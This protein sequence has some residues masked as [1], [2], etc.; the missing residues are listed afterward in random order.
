MQTVWT[1]RAYPTSGQER[2]LILP[3]VLANIRTGNLMPGSKLPAA[4][5]HTRLCNGLR[6][7]DKL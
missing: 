7:G 5:P 1:V 2:K 4:N 3:T 6:T